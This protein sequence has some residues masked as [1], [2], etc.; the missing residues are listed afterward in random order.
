[1]D[2]GTE[3]FANRSWLSTPE[4]KSGLPTVACDP[5]SRHRAHQQRA[6][7]VLGRRAEATAQKDLQLVGT[8]PSLLDE[9]GGFDLEQA[10][11][12]FLRSRRIRPPIPLCP[13]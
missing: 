8:T 4:A 3:L 10:V 13:S 6:D 5:P 7:M 11:E 12:L 9:V 2:R 1:M